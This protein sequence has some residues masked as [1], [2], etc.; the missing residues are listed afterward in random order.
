MKSKKA[1]LA[2]ERKRR[3]RKRQRRIQS[4]LRDRDWTEQDSPMF[5][6]Q[7][8]RYEVADRTQ[9]LSCG[10]IGLTHMVALRTGLRDQIDSGLQLLKRHVPYHESD[11]VLN[12]AYNLVA[13]G[14][15]L[16]DIEMRRNDEAYLNALGAQRIPD[17]TTAGDFCRRFEEGDVDQ[18]MGIINETRL[19]VWAEQAEQF[20]DEALIDVDGTVVP[21]TGECKGGMDRSYKGIWGYHPMLVSLANTREPLFVVN[22]PGNRPSEEGAAEYLQESI[23][24]CRRGGFRNVTLRG[25][26]AFSQTRYL[27]EWDDD[28]VGVLFGYPA[29]PNLV[30]T[31]RNL[32]KSDWSPLERTKHSEVQTEE[33]AKPECVKE[34]IVEDREYR[35]IRLVRESVAEF[36]YQPS[37]CNRSYRIVVVRKDLDVLRGQLLLEKDVRFFFYITNLREAAQAEIVRKANERCEQE[38]LIEQLKNGTR[39][40]HAPV[41]DLVSN[42]A[43]MVMASLAWTLKAWTALLLPTT[44]RWQDKHRAEKEELQRMEFKRFVNEFI[45][46]PAQILRTGRRIVFRLLA[47][48]R[49]VQVFLRAVEVFERP[50]QC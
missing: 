23:A 26:T 49:W 11:H 22:R 41:N 32:P 44:G 39:A 10:G 1:K 6:G 20:F 4:R 34:Q 48:R 36:E 7:S 27:D 3:M 2:S 12:I 50:L 18:L 30:K 37:E 16:D 5:S 17:P 29:C 40:L 24:L 25:D 28:N 13:G 35:N 45:Q 47:W 42:W 14:T 46:I 21:T 31:A 9:A 8:I 33:R 43:Y 19:R 38:N 15:S